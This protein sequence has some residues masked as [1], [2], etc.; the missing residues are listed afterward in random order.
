MATQSIYQDLEDELAQFYA[1]VGKELEDIRKC[2][3]EI[4][5]LKDR[6]LDELYKGQ[7]IRDDHRIV[8]SAPE[9]IIGDVSKDGT[10]NNSANSVVVIRTNHIKEEAVDR[11]VGELGSITH[12]ASKIYNVCASPGIAGDESVVGNSSQFVVQAKA[13]AMVSE[14][15]EGVFVNIPATANG[16]ISLM[17]EKHIHLNAEA[18]TE[19]TVKNIE[20]QINAIDIKA[21]TKAVTDATKKLT[22]SR[23]AIDK[24]VAD[25][26]GQYD[27][28]EK[29]RANKFDVEAVREELE[30]ENEQFTSDFVDAYKK[31]SSLAEATRMKAALEARKGAIGKAQ[32]ENLPATSVTIRAE[33]T[34]IMS[35]DADGKAFNNDTAGFDVIAKN[36][37]FS[38]DDNNTT[39]E[40]SLFSI[41]AANIDLSTWSPK[42][43]G[44]N[45]DIP[46]TGNV[47]I[48]SKNIVM[49][50]VD[51]EL[52]DC[53]LYEKAL[54]EG[55]SIKMRAENVDVCTNDTEGKG[56][57]KVNV[58]SKQIALKA[59][60]LDKE[61][62][63]EKEQTAESTLA[64]I[65]DKIY[66]G[67]ATKDKPSQSVQILADKVGIFAKTTAELQQDEAKAILQLDGGNIAL[68]GSKTTLYGETTMHGKTAFKSEVTSGK[69]S[70]KYMEVSG[71]WK[72]PCTSEGVPG[73]P[74]SSSDSLSAKLQL[75]DAPKEEGGEKK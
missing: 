28:P 51:N 2:K 53:V 10:L 21:K 55:G 75:E 33:N 46:A 73:V 64:L 9:I 22:A 17:A 54:T 16:E 52:K 7:Y 31:I 13:I 50:S 57:G 25:S 70:A 1:K 20:S 66:A 61:S 45:F 5:L 6:M 62:R 71:Q 41:A 74:D 12:K 32:G 11:N 14:D 15:T 24:T 40:N 43:D 30:R 35:A 49:E 47:H 19:T 4:M 23:L 34:H 42:P 72:G 36:T 60:D 69:I 68:T 39:M 38:A 56:K 18:P 48:T 8:I 65:S 3:Q 67:S 44:E 27:T 59:M 26:K 37:S 63:A 58:N 29:L